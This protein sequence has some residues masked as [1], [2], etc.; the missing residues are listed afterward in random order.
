MQD[1]TGVPAV[2]DLAAMRDAMAR[3]RRRSGEDQP[4][5]PVEL[6][7]DHSVQVDA[8]GTRRRVR[9]STP[10]ASSSAI[11]SA[12]RSCAGGRARSSNFSR[13]AARHGHLPPGQPRVPRARRL[14]PTTGRSGRRRLSRTRWSGTDSHTTMVNGLGVLGWGVGGIE[15]EAAMLGQP[16][17][18][19]I[20]QVVGFR[21]HGEL[22]E[23]ATATDLVLTVTADAARA[24]RRRQVR[25]VLRRRASARCRSPT[26]RRSATCRPSTASTCAIFPIDA[27][28]LALPRAHRPPA[29]ADRAGRGLRQGSRASGTT[30]HAP[31]RSSPTRSSS[32]SASVEPSL[33]GPKRPQD[34]VPLRAAS[35]GARSSVATLRRRGSPARVRRERTRQPRFE[36]R[37]RGAGSAAASPRDARRQTSSSHGDVV[38]AAITSC[39]NT[40]NPSVMLGAGLLAR[41]AVA[42]GLQRKPWVKTSLA[43]GSQVVTDYLERAGLQPSLDAARLQPRRLR[44]HDLHRQLRPA[45]ATIVD[46]VD[47]RRPRRRRGALGQPQLRGPHPPGREGQLPRLAAA[48]RRVRARRHDATSTS[49]RDP[50]GTGR[51]RRRR[52]SCA[53]SGRPNE[54]IAET[55]AA[56]ACTSEMF[57]KRYGDVFEGDEPGAA[58]DRPDG[59]A[60]SLG[61]RSSTYVQHPAVL[62]GDADE[63]PAP[64]RG[65]RRRARAGDPR[66]QHHD[67]P[68]LAGRVDQA[69]RPRRRST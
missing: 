12:T 10:S 32:T 5:R 26:A 23:G 50:L 6:V 42:R 15:A 60:L 31:S 54:E 2:V 19:L 63:P 17:S 9:A 24:R 53:T 22:P 4:A 38:I 62:R 1:F 18:M 61:R 25:R 36:H 39:T 35:S 58:L 55:V 59:R 57:R 11:T 48:R 13:R 21:L 33:A 16:V 56:G 30:E 37:V 27:E 51:G 29:R 34:R 64:L 47:E 44:L 52:S 43:P 46:A 65:H 14:R 68:H 45:A 49:L 41:K 28:T 3:D 8:F 7:I 20:P 66:R 69:R 40:S 67:R